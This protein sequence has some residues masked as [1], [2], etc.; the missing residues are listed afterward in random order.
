MGKLMRDDRSDV[1]APAG[2]DPHHVPHI[3]REIAAGADQFLLRISHVQN[4]H[5][6]LSRLDGYND[7]TAPDFAAVLEQLQKSGR[8]DRIYKNIHI[9][10]GGQA[11]LGRQGL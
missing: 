1:I 7:H 10:V 3:F 2:H 11:V 5:R 9:Q 8:S 6:A 4:I